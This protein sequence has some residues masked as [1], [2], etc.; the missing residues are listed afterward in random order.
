VRSY[1]T[2]IQESVQ[3]EH[4]TIPEYLDTPHDVDTKWNAVTYK[5]E[6]YVLWE[7]KSEWV[8]SNKKKAQEEAAK[9]YYETL[10]V[11]E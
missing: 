8:G 9:K 2:M 6:L 10:I 3:K 5:S 1:K 7:K 11:P 4:K